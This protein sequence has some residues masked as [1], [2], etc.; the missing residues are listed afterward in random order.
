MEFTERNIKPGAMQRET[1]GALPL[2]NPGEGSEM[3]E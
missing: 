2:G 3:L 1:S